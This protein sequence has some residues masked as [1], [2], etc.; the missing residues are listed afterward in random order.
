MKLYALAIV[1][2]CS[3]QPAVTPTWDSGDASPCV[4][5]Q[6]ITRERL[7]RNP[8]GTSQVLPCKAP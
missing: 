3:C 7:I 4:A 5:D 8:D 2:V 6:A 1:V